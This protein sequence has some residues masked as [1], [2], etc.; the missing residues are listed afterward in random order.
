MSYEN[1][2][3]CTIFAP[4]APP[5][6]HISFH[7]RTFTK[8]SCSNLPWDYTKCYHYKSILKTEYW[9]FQVQK[10]IFT[11]TQLIQDVISWDWT[12]ANWQIQQVPQNKNAFRLA[13][14]LCMSKCQKIN[15]NFPIFSDVFLYGWWAWDS[16]GPMLYPK[17]SSECG[18][19]CF[20][21]Q[22]S[23]TW[24]FLLPR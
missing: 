6:L 3:P 19:R 24:A 5:I 11:I 9:I 12:N 7:K 15:E 20:L 2:K 10:K 21:L 22:C 17:V 23:S 8:Y 13:H 16:H 1:L 14:K 18:D 4:S